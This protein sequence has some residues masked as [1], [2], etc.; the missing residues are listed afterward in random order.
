MCLCRTGA[1]LFDWINA[2]LAANSPSTNII[3]SLSYSSSTMVY[4]F[5]SMILINYCE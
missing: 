2:I 1:V 5:E 4:L 3:S